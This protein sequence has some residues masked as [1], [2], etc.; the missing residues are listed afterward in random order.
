M[1]DT[2][3]LG[4]P[5]I[6][7][8]QSQKHVTHNQAIVI[9]D[10]IVMLSVIDSTRT[11]PPGSPAEGDRYKVASG[12]TGAWATWDL[13]IALYTNGQWVKLAP[14]KGWTCFDEATGALTVWTGSGWTDI[15]AA[16]GY[17]TVAAAGNGTLATLGIL[18]AADNTNRLAVKSNAALFSHDDVTP[19]TGDMRIVLNKSAAGK[20][21]AFNFQDA[22]STRALFGLLGDDNFTIKV[23]PDGSA[24]KTAIV[25]DK[26]NGHIGI[27][28]SP[29]S[30]NWLAVNADGVLFNKD[31][32]G[33]MR[34]TINK[35]AAAKDAGFTLQDNFSTRALFG[36]LADD[37]FTVK[38]SPD[39]STFYTGLSIDRSSGKVS[40]PALAKVSA[41]INYD[42]YAATTYVNTDINNEDL[43]SANAFASNLFTAPSTGLYKVGYSLGWTQNGT[44]APTSMHGR[45]LKNGATEVLPSASSASNNA[46]NSGKVVICMEGIVS[47]T[48]GDTLRLQH[49]F[50]SLD[51]YASA[52]IT[53]F[54]VEQ[55][56]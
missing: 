28:G 17:L 51:G 41:Y 13:N 44:N 37:N 22:F 39:G 49:K 2:P 47:L 55:L 54:W 53:R 12:A 25:I 46:G 43:D 38:V 35:S 19:G 16:G 48:A 36:L 30:N 20:D 33:D 14:K 18:T 45:L 7:A 52:N 27:N 15:A 11:A 31:A 10:S 29:D 1:T 50:S 5:L 23:S 8:S 21:A 24:F 6:A 40:F 3:H 42:H 26:S 4:M 34:V 9:L 32:S 56:T